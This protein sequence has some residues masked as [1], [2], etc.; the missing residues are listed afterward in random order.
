MTAAARDDLLLTPRLRPQEIDDAAR[1]RFVKR[2]Y[3]PL[4]EEEAR[5]SM[6]MSYIKGQNWEISSEELTDI[7][8]LTEG[9]HNCHLLRRLFL[10]HE[11]GLPVCSVFDLA[12]ADGMCRLFRFRHEGLMLRSGAAP[13]S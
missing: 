1:R 5:K 6:I 3:I 11:R 12:N 8:R 7:A 4:P 9:S 10:A 2:L 13:S